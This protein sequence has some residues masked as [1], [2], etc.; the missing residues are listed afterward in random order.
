MKEQMAIILLYVD[1]MGIV[2]TNV[3]LKESKL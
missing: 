2:T 3:S 1:K